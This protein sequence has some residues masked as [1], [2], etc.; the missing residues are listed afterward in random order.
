MCFIAVLEVIDSMTVQAV[1][2]SAPAAAMKTSASISSY[3]PA[4]GT[5]AEECAG[6]SFHFTSFL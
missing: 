1:S 6:S 3:F 4:C 2:G 5:L